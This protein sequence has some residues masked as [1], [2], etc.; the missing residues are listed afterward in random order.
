MGDK[1]TGALGGKQ[2]KAERK[3]WES[4]RN[5]KGT[6]PLKPSRDKALDDGPNGGKGKG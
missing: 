3:V 6:F 4:R 5:P 2:G 1:D